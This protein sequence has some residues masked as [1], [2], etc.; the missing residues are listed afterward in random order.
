[1][2]KY[3]IFLLFI[4]L[5]PS[6]L[7]AQD[8]SQFTEGPVQEKPRYRYISINPGVTLE[9]VSLSIQGRS[10]DA[11]MVQ[12]DPGRVSWLLDVKSPEW[13]ISKYFGIN[14]LLHNSNF[15]LNRQSIPRILSR[16]ASVETS[17]SESGSSSSDNDSVAPKRNK[18]TEDVGTQIEGSYSMLVPIF[19]IGNPDTFRLGF[20]MGPAQVRMRGNVDFKDA[21]SNLLIAFSGPGRDNFLNNLTAFQ[22]VS[23]N[24][25]PESDPTLSYLV[26]NLSSGNNLE[27]VGYY[28]ASQ[29][30]LRADAT[31]LTAYLSGRYNAVESLAISSLMRNQVSVNATARF[32]FMMY[33]ES[34]EFIG[35]RAR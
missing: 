35:L 33:L 27:L 10:R 20:G 5:V 22:F 23:G 4:L 2:K 16:S 13:Q 24:I 34:P 17:S 21:A 18:V 9:S 30:L 8:N 12:D 3:I 25:N 26:A 6:L 19:Y 15:S 28:L 1:M 31:A 29:G 7:N 32:A 14:L 11:L